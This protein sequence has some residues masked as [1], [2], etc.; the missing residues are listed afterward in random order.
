MFGVELGVGV[1]LAVAVT[2]AVLV[3]VGVWVSKT[4]EVAVLVVP[5]VGVT[6]GA[7]GGTSGNLER[8]GSPNKTLLKPVGDPF[9]LFTT[10]YPEKAPFVSKDAPMALGGRI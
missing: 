6:I 10:I 2:A 8:P 7:G 9:S 3:A 1:L 4:V 5:G